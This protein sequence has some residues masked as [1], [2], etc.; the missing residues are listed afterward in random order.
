MHNAARRFITLIDVWYDQRRA[1]LLSAHAPLPALFDRLADADLL[2]AAGSGT[3]GDTAA[4]VPPAAAELTMRGTGGAS[5]SWNST[6]LADGTEWSAT[7][8]LGVSLAALAGLQ[9]ASFARL[10]AASRLTE[11]LSGS[12][13]PPQPDGDKVRSVLF[14][15]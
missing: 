4:A 7:G 14:S 3:D 15:Y 6:F 1:L 10:R 5:S 13:W 8:R 2:A 11:M 9:D 12:E